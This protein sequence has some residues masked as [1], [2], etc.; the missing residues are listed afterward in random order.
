MA[1]DAE[2]E[3]ARAYRDASGEHLAAASDLYRAG[4]YV[5]ANYAAGLAVECILRA[6]RNMIDPEFDSRHD[7]NA[8]F[9][10]A[11]FGG[12]VPAER[13]R[14]IGAS[15]SVVIQLWSNDLRFLSE[16]ALRKRFNKRHLFAGIRG[17]ALKE[18][19]RRLI[20][21]AAPLVQTGILQWTSSFKS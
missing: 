7:L 5:L 9:Q 12:V 13:R 8:L 15:L 20:S 14:E 17:D 18:L 21:N 10:L 1:T 4:R 3:V 2:K 16:A 6:Y 11:K 19:T